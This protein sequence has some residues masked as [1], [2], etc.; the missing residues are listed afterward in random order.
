MSEA[1]YIRRSLQHL[2]D[3]LA[4]LGH[5]ACPTTIG[6][7]LE[8]LGYRLRVN[9]KRLTGPYHPDRDKQFRYLGS[10]VEVFRAEG[11]PILSVDAKKKE[12]VGNFAQAGATWQQDPYEVNA[13]DF[14]TDAQYRAAPYGQGFQGC[15]CSINY[16][17]VV[18][19]GLANSEVRHDA[20]CVCAVRGTGAVLRDDPLGLGI[21][22][23]ARAVGRAVS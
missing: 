1:Q 19:Y 3:E 18:G 23:S 16:S 15:S 6:A 10:L 14:P 7:L 22:F 12:L 2:S 9:V 5:A 11:W 17:L 4:E 21:S 8:E 20:S 13:H